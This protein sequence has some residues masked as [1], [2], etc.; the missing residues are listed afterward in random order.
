MSQVSR[1]FLLVFLGAALAAGCGKNSSTTSPTTTETARSTET[2]G[3]K[4]SV[5]DSQFYSFSTVSPGTTDVTLIGLRPAGNL[6]ATLNTVV[7]L[8]LGVPQGTDCA[9]ANA[10]T[11]APGFQAQLSATT[12][13]SVY[14]VKIA[15]VGNLTGPVDYTIRVVHP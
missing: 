8:G 5:G 10:T 9:L 7:G 11:T 4:L 13:V 12:N 1:A 2:I 6:T 14:C 15:D 3:G